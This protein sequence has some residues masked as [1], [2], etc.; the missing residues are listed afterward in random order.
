MSE[1]IRR[2][3]R[4]SPCAPPRPPELRPIGTEWEWQ[5]GAA[6]R[7][8][9]SDVFFA[10]PTTNADVPADSAKPRQRGCAC[11]ARS[12]RDACNTRTRSMNRSACGGEDCRPVSAAPAGRLRVSLQGTASGMGGLVPGG[13]FRSATSRH[14]R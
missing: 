7:G 5:L 3:A 9:D 13:N 12:G 8:A 14:P 11:S 2:R 4:T 10:P 6:C 1:K